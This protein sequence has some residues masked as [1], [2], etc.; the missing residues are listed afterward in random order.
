MR[1]NWNRAV[2]GDLVVPENGIK[3]GPFGT[4]LSAAEYGADGVPVVS[5]GEVGYGEFRVRP[6]TPR[7]GTGVTSRLPD[8]LLREGD[9]VFGRKGAVDRSAWVSPREAGWFL[10]SDGL[11]V[12]TRDDVDSRF[13]GFQLR[14]LAVREWL[15]QHAGGSTL[16]SLNQG[17][18]ARVPLVVPPLA[19]QQAIAEVLGA[20]DD[21]IAAN[22][23]LATAT[24]TYLAALFEASTATASDA[25]LGAIA[26][27]NRSTAKPQEGHLRYIDIA[28]VGVGSFE[29]PDRM[30]W[31]DAPSRARRRVTRGDTLWSTVRPNRRSHALV[32]DDDPELIASTGLA[33]LSPRTVGFAYL[34]EA[35]KRAAFSGYLENVAEGSAYPA[36]RADRFLDAPI[37]LADASVREAFERVAAPLRQFVASADQENRTLA[38]T[39]D[40][41]LPQLLSGKL[42][43]GAAE[44]AASAAGV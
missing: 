9:I 26:D 22:T 13:V 1:E 6:E 17:T 37:P 38:A 23:T 32:L 41:L 18:L 28:S 39:R 42:R 5:V 12:R 36:V 19:E 14:S 4:V 40:A 27:V 30:S 16:L 7:V 15:L 11:R 33:V 44:A 2:L 8:Y 24:D 29:F 21:K 34:Y 35:C 43:I 20:L 31:D 10:G 3:T 25:R